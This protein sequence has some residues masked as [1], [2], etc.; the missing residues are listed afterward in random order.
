MTRAPEFHRI[1]EMLVEIECQRCKGDG[2][3]NDVECGACMGSGVRCF[4]VTWIAR[5]VNN[6]AIGAALFLSFRA[7]DNF[8]FHMGSESDIHQCTCQWSPGDGEPYIGATRCRIEE[9]R[10][11]IDED[12]EDDDNPA[13]WPDAGVAPAEAIT[14][15]PACNGIDLWAQR[16]ENDY[17]EYTATICNTCEWRSDTPPPRVADEH[18]NSLW[19]PCES[20]GLPIRDG[21]LYLHYGDDIVTHADCPKGAHA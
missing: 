15:C 20:C 9:E 2:W 17:G 3:P 10:D 6:L 12:D 21:E 14:K 5:L 16:E 13:E 8:G 18:V 19:G 1:D 11:E 4:D 7:G